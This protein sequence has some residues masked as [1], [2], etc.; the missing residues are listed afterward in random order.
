MAEEHTLLPSTTTTIMRLGKG[1]W[2]VTFPA[3]GVN[4]QIA[5]TDSVD[6]VDWLSQTLI[7][8]DGGKQSN[9]W[10]QQPETP[11]VTQAAAPAR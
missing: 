5:F 9:N 10:E 1:G 11:V 6:L 8:S 2:L 7:R 3:A 4:S